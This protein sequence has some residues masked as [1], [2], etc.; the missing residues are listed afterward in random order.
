MDSEIRHC[1][2]GKEINPVTLETH[3]HECK[4]IHNKFD[5]V[6]QSIY[7]VGGKADVQDLEVLAV[8]ADF[9]KIECE[10]KKVLLLKSLN[11]PKLKPNPEEVKSEKVIQP[12]GEE[13]EKITTS[14]DIVCWHCNNGVDCTQ[15]LFPSNCADS[16]CKNCLLKLAEIEI[17]KNG[18]V[19]CKCGTQIV[20]Q[21]LLQF[22]PKEKI[23]ELENPS[24]PL[25]QIVEC[26]GCHQ[27]FL[28]EMGKIDF[29]ITD[30]KGVRLK[31]EL[32][33]HYSNFRIRC[34]ICKKDFCKNCKMMPYHI[35]MT[36]EH[37][38]H[39]ETAKYYN[40]KEMPLLQ[41]RN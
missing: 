34:S 39:M 3:F 17:P 40:N 9:I 13:E 2:C 24:I 11:P 27:Q 19:K 7:N 26:P 28:F 21:D 23:D 35:G 38:K 16:I 31:K 1:H 15:I 12:G 14:N 30:E 5:P 20:R 33:E 36:C 22:I 25:D 18:Y 37:K 8:I 29:N 32:A 10:K 6:I 41:G 4:I